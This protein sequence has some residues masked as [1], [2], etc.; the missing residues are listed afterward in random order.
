MALSFR[1]AASRCASTDFTPFPL[2]AFGAMAEVAREIDGVGDAGGDGERS[3][4]LFRLWKRK[5]AAEVSEIAAANGEDRGNTPVSP[6]YK[7]GADVALFL[8]KEP[9]TISPTTPRLTRAVAGGA[10]DTE[11]N[12]A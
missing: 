2:S 11:L 3:A 6:A 12:S 1:S 5:R 8:N 7:E 10:V 9:P 4:A